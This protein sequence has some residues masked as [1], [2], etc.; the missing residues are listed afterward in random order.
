M[1]KEAIRKFRLSMKLTQEAFARE[2]GVTRGA[3][4]KW[5][6]GDVKPSPLAMNQIERLKGRKKPKKKGGK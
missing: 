5:E 3:V 2:L 4:A 1:E 6:A